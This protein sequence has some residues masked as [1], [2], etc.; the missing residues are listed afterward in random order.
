ME[1][2]IDLFKK[3]LTKI[4][5]KVDYADIRA[6]KGNNTSII[7]KDNQIQ[8]INT[9]LSTVARIRVLNNGAWGF[10]STND[11]SKLEEISEKAIKISNSL[12][13]DIELAECEIV[14]DNV[15][16]DR[17][18]SLSDVSIEDKKE[19]IQE[20]NKASNVGKWSAPLSAILMGKAK[21][22]LLA[23]KEA[24]LLLTVQEWH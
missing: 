19:L 22:H 2:H 15:K 8:E 7:M 20:A 16:T 12:T 18:I 17:K 21:A 3:I 9:G 14:E 13:G 23:L 6:G 24:Q 5:D 11:F 1:E 10:A 4:D